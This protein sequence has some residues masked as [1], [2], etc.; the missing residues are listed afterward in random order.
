MSFRAA[1]YLK[2]SLVNLSI[3]LEFRLTNGIRL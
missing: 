1:T 2:M 3:R